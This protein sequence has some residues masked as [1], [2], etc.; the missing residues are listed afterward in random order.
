MLTAEVV[1][2]KARELG[3]D[4]VGIADAA[5]LNG[6]PPDPAHPQIPARISPEIRSCVAFFK[7]IPA[8]AFR[9]RDNACIHH[10]DQ[11]VLREMHRSGHSYS[12]IP[13][14]NDHWA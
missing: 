7:R 1:K 2:A 10:A 9:A 5:V 13:H 4:G 11:L 6:Y 8:G 12:R 3:A 14:A